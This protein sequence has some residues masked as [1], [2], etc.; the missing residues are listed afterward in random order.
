MPMLRAKGKL[1]VEPTKGRIV[2]NVSNDFV[3]YY[4]QFLVKRYW[5]HMNTPM[6]G[7]HI[8]IYNSRVHSKTDWRKALWYHN[9]EIE[10]EYD[11]NMVEGGFNKGFIMFYM[12]IYSK[13]LEDFKKR[14]GIVE[15]TP[16]RYK[17]LHLTICTAGKSGA[18]YANWWPKLIEI[19]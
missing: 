19:K 3:R 2:L 11:I 5:I 8:T 16:E 4:S 15:I 17:G 13:E 18:P 10:F 7:S 6:H 14:C 1:S 12:M 9:K